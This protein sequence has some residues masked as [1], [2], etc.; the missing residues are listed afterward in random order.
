MF[1]L[2]KAKPVSKLEVKDCLPGSDKPIPDAPSKDAKHFV[3]K[4]PLYGPWPEGTEEISFG[5]GCFWCSENLFWKVKGV[6]STQVG[7]MGGVTKNPSYRDI[8]SGKT[9]H[10][11]VTRVV[12]DPKAV[13]LEDLLKIFWE[14]HNPTTMNQQGNDRGTQYRSGIYYTTPEQAELCQKSKAQYQKAL[15]SKGLGAITTEIIKAP[16]FWIA[17]TQHQQ[18]DAKPGSRDYCGLA[19]LGIPLPKL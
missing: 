16:E 12:Y 1:S 15:T 7:Y 9:N 3:L 4:T 17:E 11:E 5:M 6:Y 8:C 13:P 10:N 2:F 18:Y 14:T 19:P